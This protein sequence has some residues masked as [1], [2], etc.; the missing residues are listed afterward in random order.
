MKIT[1]PT[2]L[3]EIKLHQYQAFLKVSAIEGQTE[4]FLKHKMIQIFCDVSLKIVM[5]MSFKDVEEISGKIGS[6]FTDKNKL[7]NR[8]KLNGVDYGFVPNLDNITSGEL[9]DLDAYISD[10]QKMHQAM[11]VLF[12]PITKSFSDRYLIEK[13]EGSD[14]YS[15]VLKDMPLD[16]ALGAMVFFWDLGKDLVS[17]T[18][19]YLAENPEVANIVN[20]HNLENAGDGTLLSME[21]L[22]ET[23]SDLMKSQ[24]YQYT[25]F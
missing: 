20:K 25:S 14:K 15:E 22:K 24:N 21:Q 5:L 12:R 2:S 23:F 16:V 17:S 19:S 9:I 4:D 3:N 10:W 6:L 7:I 1:I 8:F 13:Y 18:M 11:A